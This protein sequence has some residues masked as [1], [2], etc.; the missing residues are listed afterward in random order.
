MSYKLHR[1]GIK[2]DLLVV[3]PCSS[4]WLDRAR[5]SAGVVLKRANYDCEVVIVEEIGKWSGWVKAHNWAYKHLE[6]EYYLYGCADYYPGKHFIE[7]GMH[8]LKEH[9]AGL[10]AFNDGKWNG[11]LATTGIVS[12][13]WVNGIYDGLFNPI[14]KDHYADT[15]LSLFGIS[16]R[17]MLYSASA[18]YMEV[19]YESH[20]VNR[21]DKKKFNDRKK[22]CFG[23][24]I[25]KELMEVFG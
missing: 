1:Q 11:L 24:K 14:Y 2:S 16:D 4:E 12:R 22:D 8:A 13:E 5:M 9:K 15:E 3:I 19:D 20:G 21:E 23:G 6:S 25:R 10:F 18:V 17:T 7:I